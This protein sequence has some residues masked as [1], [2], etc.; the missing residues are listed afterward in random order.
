MKRW[1]SLRMP[2]AVKELPRLERRAL[3]ANY[4]GV[5]WRDK[6]IWLYL[7]LLT[8]G[9]VLL[10]CFALDLD[11]YLSIPIVAILGGIGSAFLFG[12]SI[13][14]KAPLAERYLEEHGGK[15]EPELVIRYLR[16]RCTMANITTLVCYLAFTAALFAAVWGWIGK[17][18]ME[19]QAELM[20]MRAGSAEAQQDIRSGTLRLYK[21]TEDGEEEFTGQKEGVFEIWSWPYFPSPP[22]FDGASRRCDEEFVRWYNRIMRDSLE[23]RANSAKDPPK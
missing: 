19:V 10:V 16:R 11:R 9:A 6:R 1:W 18:T 7:G 15:V 20:A 13:T 5:L 12:R 14:L 3:W 4:S 21:L 22:I 17:L 23:E 2:D 8:L